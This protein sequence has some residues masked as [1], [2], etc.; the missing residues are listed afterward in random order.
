MQIARVTD[1]RQVYLIYEF[2]RDTSS[3]AILVRVA[4]LADLTHCGSLPWRNYF[5]IRESRFSFSRASW[6][7]SHFRNYDGIFAFRST[8]KF[9]R[10][11][12][13]PGESS[14]PR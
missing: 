5:A 14:F 7:P 6:T 10:E 11:Q 1:H 9:L 2:T 8:D 12:T 13:T 4:F 3:R